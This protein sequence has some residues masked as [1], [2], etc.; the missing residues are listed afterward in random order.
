MFSIGLDAVGRG[1][2]EGLAGR[3][4]TMGEGIR[5]STNE[6]LTLCEICVN[7]NDSVMRMCFVLFCHTHTE[8]T[9]THTH[10]HVYTRTHMQQEETL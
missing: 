6:L 2:V 4:L 1:Y 9:H 3:L 7:D 10:T 8:P 5:S